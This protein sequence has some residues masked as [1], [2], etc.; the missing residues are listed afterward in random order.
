MIEVAL[1]ISNRR[2][3]AGAEEDRR[4]GSTPKEQEACKLVLG[5]MVKNHITV[6]RRME[7][8]QRNIHILY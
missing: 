5:D 2:D 1:F 7:H 4:K 8:Y 6:I 3:A